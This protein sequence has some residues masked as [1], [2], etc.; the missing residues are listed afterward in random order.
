MNFSQCIAFTAL[1]IIQSFMS[2]A[3]TPQVCPEMTRPFPCKERA[4]YLKSAVSD[5]REIRRE[6]P[7]LFI[8]RFLDL[9]ALFYQLYH[10]AKIWRS[11][12][13]G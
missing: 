13:T 5:A 7:G 9:I 11:L 4:L 2:V 6:C 12:A 8:P 3:G 10:A 1:H